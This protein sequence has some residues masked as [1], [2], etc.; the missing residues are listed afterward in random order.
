MIDIKKLKFEAPGNRT[1]LG[2]LYLL[3]ITFTNFNPV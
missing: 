2:I 1:P 3:T